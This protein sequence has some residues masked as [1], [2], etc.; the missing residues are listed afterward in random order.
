MYPAI[1]GTIAELIKL[2]ARL[3]PYLYDLLW[4][5]H[6]AFEPMIRPTY[7][8]FPGDPACF[9]ENDEMMLGANLLVA[10]MVEPGQSERRVTL[11]QGTGW[12]DFWRGTRHQGGQTVS[13]P[14]LLD[15]QT[16]LFV[17]EGSAIPLNLAEQHFNRPAD[18]RGFAIFAGIGRFE[19]T[20]HEDDGESDAYRDQWRLSVSSDAKTIQI[21]VEKPKGA[22]S[23]ILLLPASEKRAVSPAGKETSWEGWRR[24]ELEL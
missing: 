18:Q 3:T 21:A 10:A 11:P 16:P 4:R 15:A 1:S 17:R 20:C 13:V 2:R 19:A 9:A 23:L 24:L 5:S 6:S 14:A 7:Y 8:D 22:T 12:Y